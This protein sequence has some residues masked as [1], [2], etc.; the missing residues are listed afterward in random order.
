MI[1]GLTSQTTMVPLNFWTRKKKNNNKK[2][3]KIKKKILNFSECRVMKALLGTKRKNLFQ[4]SSKSIS[5][6]EL[7]KN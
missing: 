2:K 7:S 1:T 6:H 5:F 3:L 4:N